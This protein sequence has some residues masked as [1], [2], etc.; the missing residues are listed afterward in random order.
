MGSLSIR[1]IILSQKST[2]GCPLV[3]NTTKT[4]HT[5]TDFKAKK[6]KSLKDQLPFAGKYKNL[7]VPK[8]DLNKRPSDLEIRAKDLPPETPTLGERINRDVYHLFHQKDK[9]S[10][11]HNLRKYP[12]M[13]EEVVEEMKE[14]LR[15]NPKEGFKQSFRMVKEEIRKYGE[16]LRQNISLDPYAKVPTKPG[17]R[18]TEWEF[19]TEADLE[20]WVLTKDSDWGEGYSAAEMSLSPAGHL[21]LQGDLSTRVPADGRTQNAGYVAISSVPRRRAFAREQL[22]EWQHWTHLTFN[23]RGDGRKYLLNIQVKRD[24][25]IIW[26]DRWSYPLFT[27]GGPYWQYVKIPWSK[28]LLTSKGSVQDKQIQVPLKY[29]V[30]G[31]TLT[32]AD[33]ISGPFHLEMKDVSLMYDPTQDDETFAYESYKIPDFWAGY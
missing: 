16:E 6:K 24:F 19:K 9:K 23:I 3:F 22:M 33:G 13:Y 11:Y 10:G 29:G 12:G 2:H 15:S 8:E 26:N 1:S 32:L 28:F 17:D 7:F 20:Q 30:V 4:F 31:I 14:Q 18:R 27:R 25:D 5:T 21:L